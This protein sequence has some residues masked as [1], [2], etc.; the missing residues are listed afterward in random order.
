MQD[1][2]KKVLYFR[3]KLGET[4]QT[5]RL[6]NGNVSRNKFANEYGLNE[7]N[8]GKIENG[9]IDCKFI[10]LY[11]T[12]EA[13]GVDFVEFAQQFKNKLG[14]DFTLIDE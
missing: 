13:S 5:T 11:K 10:T 8:L 2:K 12:I 9:L 6:D 1:N 3:E 7:S 14:D 4:L